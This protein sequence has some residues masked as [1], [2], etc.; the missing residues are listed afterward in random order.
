MK[1]AELQPVGHIA[2]TPIVAISISSS[3]SWISYPRH[4]M[5]TLAQPSADVRADLSMPVLLL[6][7]PFFWR[8]ELRGTA[9]ITY[10]GKG[11]GYTGGRPYTKRFKSV[12][13][14]SAWAINAI[15]TKTTEGY[16]L[17][18]QPNPL[19]ASSAA[20]SPSQ[21]SAVATTNTAST[22]QNVHSSQLQQHHQGQDQKSFRSG[23]KRTPP[24]ACSEINGLKETL[25]E[26]PNMPARPQ[27]VLESTHPKEA[28]SVVS[29][30]PLTPTIESLP[31]QIGIRALAKCAPL[32]A[33]P[34][35]D[36][37]DHEPPTKRVKRGLRGH[38]PVHT[39]SSLGM[40][41][42]ASNI[43]GNI[44]SRQLV[45]GKNT[46]D[47]VFDVMLVSIDVAKNQDKFILLQ[48]IE[49]QPS[50]SQAFLSKRYTLYERW[51]RSGTAGQS[52]AIEYEFGQLMSAIRKFNSI[53]LQKTGLDWE[54]A[55]EDPPIEGK[56]RYVYQNFE[57]KNQ[58]L[59]GETRIAQWQYW[60]NDGVDGK[61]TGWYDYDVDGNCVVEQL[62][63]EFQSNAWLSQ[64]V[65]KSGPYSYLVDLRQMTQM[66]TVLSPNTVRHIRR[67]PRD[68][69]AYINNVNKTDLKTDENSGDSDPSPPL[70]DESRAIQAKQD[71]VKRKQNKKQNTGE[72]K[73]QV[74]RQSLGIRAT[75]GGKITK[76]ISQK[77][78]VTTRTRKPKHQVQPVPAAVTVADVVPPV[79]APEV[80]KEQVDGSVDAT[81][82]AVDRYCPSSEN[83]KVVADWDVT[84]NQ[85]NV[86]GSNNNNKYYR[87]QMLQHGDGSYHVWTRWGR[88]GE[89]M[90]NQM[91]LIGPFLESLKAGK[92]F[93]SKFKSKAGFEWA[94]RETHVPVAGKYEVL[95]MESEPAMTHASSRDNNEKVILYEDSKLDSTTRDLVELLFKEDMYLDALKEFDIDVRR[96]PL[97]RLT[98][99]QIEKGVDVLKAIEEKLEAG[100]PSHVD[101]ERLSSKF[102]TVLPHDFGRRRPPIIECSARLQRCFDMCNVL[103]D[104][105]TATAMM[106]EAKD[107]QE[108]Q[109]DSVD[110]S[111][112]KKVP[113]K[114][115]QQFSRLRADLRLLEHGST[116]MKM[117]QAAFEKTNSASFVGSV[118]LLNAWRVERQDEGDRFRKVTKKN[119]QLLWHGSHIG[120]ISAILA[121]GLR[122]MPHS[123]GRVGCGIYLA[124][125][126]SKSLCYTTP[127]AQ[128]RVGCLFLA[129][130]ALGN[131][132]KL[133]QDAPSLVKPPDGF[134][135]VRACGRQSP[136][137]STTAKLDGVTVKAATSAPVTRH[138]CEDSSFFQDEVL[139]Y[140]EAQIRL[141][142]IIM[143]KF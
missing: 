112:P 97:G 55:M 115:D 20:A 24:T 14:A 139:V 116:E 60:V 65:V 16:Q 131:E 30:S 93:A 133:L 43:I 21:S 48:L 42:P 40:V 33:T 69:I 128:K 82:I 5:A 68:V 106:N 101:L 96:M 102:Y 143:V 19:K 84:M 103:R 41:D 113:A 105:E 11:E 99:D 28:A 111:T 35:I 119:H 36:H 15:E 58:M 54:R 123:G 75:V 117:I 110:N 129:E 140:D 29:G 95:K 98:T 22:S 57:Q 91:K 107:E 31:S 109:G 135:S 120:S 125:E 79:K 63:F 73:Q 7:G 44:Y 108:G 94:E 86:M 52:M 83:Y 53:F 2:I 32:I 80:K 90:E 4:E 13:R 39:S 121:T 137:L 118:Q 124:N 49:S 114:V 8:I 38:S 46:V 87:M 56:Y 141:R 67:V 50:S 66:N 72:P 64:R 126:T 76:P 47:Q 25:C 27:H 104:M 89:T 77:P 3:K 88:V 122:I 1:H 142:Y 70:P 12:K 26:P 134:D 59:N 37:G 132:F 100:T 17:S 45:S 51:G 130:A 136:D 61:A 71:S 18:A 34:A 23:C 85:T 62:F 10:R 127:A 138:A 78:N 6:N 9:V 81:N 74:H 92:A